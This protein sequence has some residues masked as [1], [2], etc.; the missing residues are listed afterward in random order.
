[1]GVVFAKG[2]VGR[3]NRSGFNS[4]KVELSTNPNFRIVAH[5]QG[6]DRPVTFQGNG[7]L[8]G[9]MPMGICP[10]CTSRHNN[11]EGETPSFKNLRTWWD[12]S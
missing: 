10:R 8:P 11:G 4:S 5:F 1:M 9:G 3:I 7:V 12:F 6:D 2:I